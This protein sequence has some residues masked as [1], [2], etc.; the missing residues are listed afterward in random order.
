MATPSYAGRMAA[1]LD[2][3]R[4]FALVTV[5]RAQGGAGYV[6]GQKLIVTD[7][8][9]VEGDVPPGAVRE[10][11]A[12][13]AQA[14]IAGE[15][16]QLARFTPAGAPLPA[17]GGSLRQAELREGAVVEVSIQPHLP[18]EHLIIAGA[19]HIGEPLAQIAKVLGYRV[20]VVDDREHFAN[21][22]RFPD[23]DRVIAAGFAETMAQ[24]RLHMRTYIVLVTRGHEH[25]EAILEQIINSPAPYIGMIGS[26]RRVLVVFER[27]VADGIP[28]EKLHRVYAPIGLDIGARWPEEIALAIMAEIVNLRRGGGAPSLALRAQRAGG[29]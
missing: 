9:T 4:P 23:A 25:D 26:K 2:E 21:R 18:Q 15:H 1:L 22:E 6:P 10:A 16:I 19:G 28:D 8:G 11:I 29:H 14:A 5:I 13:A 17:R 3:E 12:A 27:L 7:C 20:T 24:L